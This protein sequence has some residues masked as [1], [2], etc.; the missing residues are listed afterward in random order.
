MSILNDRQVLKTSDKG[1]R[2]WVCIF[3]PII[4]PVLVC[5]KYSEFCLRVD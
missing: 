4:F 2:E 3:V 1:S 5:N